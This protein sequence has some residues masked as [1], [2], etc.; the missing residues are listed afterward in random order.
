MVI[1][2]Y[3]I[4]SFEVIINTTEN[5]NL[6]YAEQLETKALK[7]LSSNASDTNNLILLVD[8]AKQEGITQLI[9]YMPY[10]LDEQQLAELNHRIEGTIEFVKGNSEY[11]LFILD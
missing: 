2:K 11:L 3:L 4:P 10:S 5:N 6:S 1:R 7:V 9:V 8:L